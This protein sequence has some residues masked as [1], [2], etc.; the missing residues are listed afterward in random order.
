MITFPDNT[1]RNYSVAIRSSEPVDVGAALFYAYGG[2]LVEVTANV[3]STLAF[4]IR[5]SA[6]NVNTNSCAL[7]TLSTAASS[8]CSYR[9]RIGTNA[10]GGFQATIAANHDLAMTNSM[11]TMTQVVNDTATPLAGTEAYGLEAFGASAGGRL[12][13]LYTQP[14]VMDTT[15]GYTFQTNTSPVPTSTQ[16]F[17]HYTTGAFDPGSAPQLTLTTLVKHFANISTG[18]PAGNYSQTVTY[19]VTAYF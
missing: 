16:N 12:A 1:P 8:T 14:V 17:F 7:G 11:A 9:L 13:G 2:N 19:I 4:S 18:T 3:P 15:A 5:D 6:D 10:A